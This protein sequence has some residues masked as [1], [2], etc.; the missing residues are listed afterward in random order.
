MIFAAATAGPK[1]PNT[2]P[3]WNPRA[4]H[5]DGGAVLHPGFLLAHELPRLAAARRQRAEQHRRE[6]VERD[7]LGAVDHVGREIVVAESNDPLRKLPAERCHRVL[8]IRHAE[9]WSADVLPGRSLAR[10]QARPGV[11]STGGR[12]T[13]GART[14]P[15]S[16][17][18]SPA[19]PGGRRTAAATGHLSAIPRGSACARWSPCT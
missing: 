12:I 4:V 11:S 3:A 16:A 6:A 14:P 7:A 8:L 10:G 9:G 18:C 15:G 13:A 17:S 2:T 5:H 1:M 19:G